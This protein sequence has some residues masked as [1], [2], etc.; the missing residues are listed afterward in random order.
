MKNSLGF[1]EGSSG[2]RI[3]GHIFPRLKLSQKGEV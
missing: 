1:R 2:F 3:L